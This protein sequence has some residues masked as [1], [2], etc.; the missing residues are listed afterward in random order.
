M[1]EADGML[2]SCELCPRRCSVNRNRETG[3]CGAGR[4]VLLALVSLHPC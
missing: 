4:L 3:F 2:E 1:M